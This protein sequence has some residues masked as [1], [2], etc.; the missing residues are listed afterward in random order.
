[1]VRLSFAAGLDERKFTR[2]CFPS[3]KFG[4]INLVVGN[5][6]RATQGFAAI[7]RYGGVF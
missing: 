3:C 2:N 7:K 5:Q 4:E 6:A 1:M